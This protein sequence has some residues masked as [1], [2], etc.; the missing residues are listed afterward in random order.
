MQ[1]AVLYQDMVALTEDRKP[2]NPIQDNMENYRKLLSL[3]ECSKRSERLL[4]E[5]EREGKGS[6]PV[7]HSGGATPTWLSPQS[8]TLRL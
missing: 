4:A 1:E 3:G 8:A 2:Q 5:R 7:T 6:G